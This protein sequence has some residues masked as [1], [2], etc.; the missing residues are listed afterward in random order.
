MSQLTEEVEY[1]CNVCKGTFI[2][3]RSNEK[4]LKECEKEFGTR[5][6]VVVICDDCYKKLP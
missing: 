2:S 3:D 4:A 1:T 6:D 5:E